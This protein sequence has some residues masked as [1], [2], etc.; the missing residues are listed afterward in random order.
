MPA[1]GRA[2]PSPRDWSGRLVRAWNTRGPLALAL[3]P[4]SWIFGALAAVRRALWRSGV[5][6]AQRLPCPVVVVG[7]RIAGGAGKTPTTIAIVSHLRRRGWQVGVVSR[8]HGRS[9]DAPLCVDARSPASAAGDEPLLIA[10]RCSV[11]VAVGRERAAA[12]RL[13]LREHPRLDLIVADDGL[14]HLALARDVEV[15]VFD[16]RGAGNGWLLPAGPL[17]EPVDAP[18]AAPAQL[19]LYNAAQPSTALPGWLGQRRLGGFVRLRDWWQGL[20]AQARPAELFDGGTALA[21]AGIAVPRR[22]FDALRATGLAI[23]ELALPDHHDFARLPWPAQT[24]RV[25]LTEKDAVKLDPARADLASAG[26]DIW[27]AQLDFDPEPGFLAALDASL[28]RPPSS[29]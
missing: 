21:A 28:P 6:K 9:G 27:V 12:A 20:P 5:L 29:N 17:R 2:A 4:L 8:G 14:Q 7:N 25:V 18:A 11:P 22:F 16:E 1:D 3:L 15:V 13:L 19:V 10:R 26:A 23:E 24:Q